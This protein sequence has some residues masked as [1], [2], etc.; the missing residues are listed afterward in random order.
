MSYTNKTPHKISFFQFLAC[1]TVSKLNFKLNLSTFYHVGLT[2]LALTY[3]VIDMP[4]DLISFYIPIQFNIIIPMKP[5]I[6]V[7]KFSLLTKGNTNS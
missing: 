7:P 1:L 4:L 2:N 3:L 6:N 5:I